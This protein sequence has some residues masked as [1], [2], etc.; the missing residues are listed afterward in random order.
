MRFLANENFPGA[1][2]V[3]LEAAG[4]DVVWVRTAA[5]GS[6]DPEVLA[7]AARDEPVLITFDK[8]FGELAKGAVLPKGC[9]V[10]LLRIPMPR[11]H[12]VGQQIAS[13][14]MA[15]DDRAGHFSVVEIRRVRTR[16]L[17]R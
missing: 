6:S 2:V 17:G 7:W 12:E 10:I 1:A 3:A 14:I 16:P 8:D 13:L 11:P 4:N 15:R 5:P 9:G